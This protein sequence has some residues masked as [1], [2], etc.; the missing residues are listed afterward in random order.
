VRNLLQAVKKPVV[1]DG[2]G[3]TAVA[4]HIQILKNRKHPTVVTPH[5]GEMSRIAHK[6]VSEITAD[7][8]G[9]VREISQAL[10]VIIVLKGAH[11]LIGFEDG[12]IFVNMSGNSGMA[13]AGSGDTLTGTIAAMF[14]LGLPLEN[15]VKT[16]VFLHGLAGDT[17]AART[18]EDGMT[19]SDILESLPRT[20]KYY[21]SAYDRI[22]ENSCGTIFLV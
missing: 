4:D 7:R 12:R 11:S 9:S 1:L 8:I 6:P 17:A 15:A 13:T 5:P 2:D 20:V 14:G 19:A 21:R 18:G 16:G 3:I 10:G 22:V